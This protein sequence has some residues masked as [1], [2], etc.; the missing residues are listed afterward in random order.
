MI[1]DSQVLKNKYF[2]YSN[3]NQKISL[4]VKKGNIVCIKK[5]LFSD[6]LY[7]DGPVI[8]NICCNPSYIS[9]EYA[10]SYYGLI[11]EYVSLYTSAC[12]SL[13]ENKTYNTSNIS[14]VYQYIPNNVFHYGITFIKNK[15]GINYKIA[16]KEKAICDTLY[17]KY[18]VRSIKD[19]EELL[20]E[21]LR[22]D[23]EDFLKLD[24]NFIL[25]IAPLYR[26][27]TL[28]TLIKYIE[29]ILKNENNDWRN[30]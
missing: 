25:E 5:G 10:L 8:A 21:N 23:E 2:S 24:L 7:I 6:N 13:K 4:E 30:N 28:N 17:S 27:N 3:I 20:F 15:D 11:P 19:L 22:I 29:R 14:F 26:S 12:F 16:T 1:Y 9:F 18:P